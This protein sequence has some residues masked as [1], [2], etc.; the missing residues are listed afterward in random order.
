MNGTFRIIE[1]QKKVTAKSDDILPKCRQKAPSN[2]KKWRQ[3]MPSFR[4]CRKLWRQKVPSNPKSGGKKCRHIL[5]VTAKSAVIS[6]YQGFQGHFPWPEAFWR[7]RHKCVSGKRLRVYEENP[8][9]SA[10]QFRVL[11]GIKKSSNSFYNHPIP[12]TKITQ[13]TGKPTPQLSYK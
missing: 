5:K 9:A 1:E 8:N 12:Q 3:K 10:A 13:R 7:W 4:K 6:H 11:P 2:S